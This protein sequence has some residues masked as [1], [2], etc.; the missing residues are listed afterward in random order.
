M[1]CRQRDCAPSMADFELIPFV[2]AGYAYARLHSL[3]S[4]RAASI[5]STP[6]NIEKASHWLSIS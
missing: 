6:P 5:Y 4:V 1:L 3:V 2:S